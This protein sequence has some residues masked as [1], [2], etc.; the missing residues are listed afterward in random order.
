MED[1]TK[2]NKTSKLELV[3]YDSQENN[4]KFELNTK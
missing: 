2:Q 4:Q 3:T 1:T